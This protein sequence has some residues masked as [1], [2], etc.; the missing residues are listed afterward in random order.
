MKIKWFGM[1]LDKRIIN[2]ET[3]KAADYIDEKERRL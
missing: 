2:D 1:V 3:I